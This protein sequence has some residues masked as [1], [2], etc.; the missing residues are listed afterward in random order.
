[1]AAMEFILKWIIEN[2][3]SVTITAIVIPCLIFFFRY[4]WNN[5]IFVVKI[6]P[7]TKE[8]ICDSSQYRKETFYVYLAN[9]GS[10]PIYE[11]HVISHHPKEVS[12]TLY[13]D[14]ERTESVKLGS[15]S[16]GTA[17]VLV[18]YDEKN[19]G[20]TDTVINNL[21]PHETIKLSV[22]IDKKN[23]YKNFELR[24]EA[25]FNSK[26]PKPILSSK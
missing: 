14:K 25:K 18:G 22:E 21:A 2:W 4:L 6:S 23:Y 9:N 1:V 20:L 17:F 15:V 5:H 10:R 26:I 13:P 7:K 19:L 16:I 24:T 3:F 11:I 8:I 12:V